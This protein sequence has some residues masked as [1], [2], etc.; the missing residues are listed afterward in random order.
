MMKFSI[1]AVV[2]SMAAA[3]YQPNKEFDN[4]TIRMRAEHIRSEKGGLADVLADTHFKLDDGNQS[5]WFMDTSA[6]YTAETESYK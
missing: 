6:L 1:G 4:G 3:T 2:A 5:Y